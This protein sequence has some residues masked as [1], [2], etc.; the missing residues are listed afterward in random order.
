M[1]GRYAGFLDPSGDSGDSAVFLSGLRASSKYQN[2][3]RKEKI[4]LYTVFA[5]TVFLSGMK[6]RIGSAFSS[7]AFFY[8]ILLL[9]LGTWIA[10]RKNLLL[11]S[12]LVMTYNSFI[13][14]LIYLSAFVLSLLASGTKVPVLN[15][16]LAD[17]GSN[18]IFC[19]LRL[20]VLVLLFPFV[21]RLRRGEISG[22]IREYEKPLLIWGSSFLSLCW[23][24]RTFWNMAFIICPSASR[25]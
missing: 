24:T 5:V 8:G 19:L 17:G 14:L 10:Y 18:A 16:F 2:M 6:Y 20:C 3:G 1:D 22:Q 21:K 9:I 12:G 4:I 13:L 11:I 23:N 15:R 7:L 25:Q